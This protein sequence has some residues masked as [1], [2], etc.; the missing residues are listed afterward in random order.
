M[1]QVAVKGA[2]FQRELG[3]S[4]GLLERVR[5]CSH[6]GKARRRTMLRVRRHAVSAVCMEVRSA[7]RMLICVSVGFLGV[8]W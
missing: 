7:L 5:Y 1:M 2:L 6:T 8:V 4:A 3:I